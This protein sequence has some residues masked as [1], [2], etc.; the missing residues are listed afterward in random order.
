MMKCAI[1]KKES[2]YSLCGDCYDLAT[3]CHKCDKYKTF[4]EMKY[5]IVHDWY[6]CSLKCL[7]EYAKNEM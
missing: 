1:C 4:K 3:Q 2:E 6:F 7:K 5:K